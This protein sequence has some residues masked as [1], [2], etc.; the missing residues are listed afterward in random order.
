M[1]EYGYAGAVPEE[2]GHHLA[3]HRRF[4]EHVVS[5]RAA[6]TRGEKGSRDALL[7]FLQNWLLDHIMST[8]K[9]LGQFIGASRDT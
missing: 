2:A 3:A 6:A 4:S 9:R 1:Q 7:Y 8:D 5:L